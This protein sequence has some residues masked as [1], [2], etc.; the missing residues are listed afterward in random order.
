[1]AYSIMIVD[2]TFEQL[3]LENKKKRVS[4]LREL[5]APPAILKIEEEQLA[6]G[7]SLS[8]PLY[9][10]YRDELVVG[11]ESVSLEYAGHFI[12]AYYFG[13]CMTVILVEGQLLELQPNA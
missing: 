10:K 8:G 12:D 13:N 9:D 3:L 4:R 7:V 5:N 11:R 6:A 1:M 2:M